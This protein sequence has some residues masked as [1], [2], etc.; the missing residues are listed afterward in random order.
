MQITASI[1]AMACITTPPIDDV[2]WCTTRPRNNGTAADVLDEEEDI[3][4]IRDSGIVDRR[5]TELPGASYT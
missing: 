2:D 3:V 4:D 1:C 5:R